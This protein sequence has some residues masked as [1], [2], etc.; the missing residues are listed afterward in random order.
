LKQF[1][2][3]AKKG[4]KLASPYV[5]SCF[6]KVVLMSEPIGCLPFVSLVIVNFNGKKFLKQCL[7][8][9][10]KTDYPNY[11][12]IIVD[13]ASTDGSLEELENYFGSNS[14]IKIIKNQKNVG[15]SEGCNIGANLSNGRYLVFLDSDI[16][17]DSKNW[18]SEL[19][20]VVEN[21]K[22][23]GLAQA[24]IV[25]SEDKTRLDCVCLAIDVLG[26]WAAN[27]GSLGNKL[28]KN[29]EIMAA[30]SGCCIIRKEV[31]NNS[32]GFDND[33]FIYDDDTDLSLRLRIMGYRILFIPSSEVIHRSGVLR[34]V[35][36]IGPYYSAKNRL[37]TAIKNY[38]FRN[39]WWKFSFLI[40]SMLLVS[41]GF[42]IVK[43][44]NEAKATLKGITTSIED[45]RK[46]WKKRL[47]FQVKRKI[48]D[49]ELVKAGFIKNNFQYTL[50]DFRIKL[51]YM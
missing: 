50:Q 27:Y 13:N 1:I 3:C 46:I 21:D 17:F 33:Y 38:E 43:K 18:L 47:L 4:F 15:H 29:F 36:G 32:G 48:K 35:S 7:L 14:K 6:H 20:K 11:E 42:F 34:G 8:T 16:E 12:V 28:K 41:A 37:R 24:K 39:L 2:V 44:N 49:S 45:L 5:K 10:L 40:F 31:F 19:V 9:L 25:L 30:S 23:I 26:T 51:Q 22:T